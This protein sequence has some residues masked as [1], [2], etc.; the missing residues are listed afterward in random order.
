VA[1]QHE[2]VTN[3]ATEALGR[4]D[5]GVR[6]LLD[7]GPVVVVSRG[8]G[9]AL[10]V[11]TIGTAGSVAGATGERRGRLGS[12]G[13]DDGSPFVR[14]NLA[15]DSRECAMV[16]SGGAGRVGLGVG[17]NGPNDWATASRH[18][19]AQPRGAGP[20]RDGS[21]DAG[22]VGS[23]IRKVVPCPSS[24][25]TRSTPPASVIKAKVVERPSP[26]PPESGRV[27]K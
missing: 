2:H 20:G 25:S 11:S 10:G 27:V 26:V 9:G 1:P 16:A 4:I 22:P 21:C 5:E 18:R 15:I 13:R 23:T 24:L 8:R 6:L 19:K 17:S 3:D 7:D 14:W 12:P